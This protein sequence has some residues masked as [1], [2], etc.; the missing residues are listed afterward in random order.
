MKRSLLPEKEL[1]QKARDLR[2]TLLTMLH[3]AGSGHPG[4]SLSI[5]D[6]LVVLFYRGLLETNPEDP[7]WKDRDRLILS[8]GHAC[9]ALYVVLADNGFFPKEELAYLRKFGHLLHQGSADVK[10]PGIEFPG[11]SL[12]QGLSGGIGMAL[13]ARYLGSPSHIFVIMG[14]GESQEGQIWEALMAGGH[15]KLK[16][17]TAILDYNKL[18]GDGPVEK[19]MRLEPLVDKIR[20]FGWKVKEIDGHD[21]RQIEEAFRDAKKREED[22]PVYLIAH[23]VKGKGVSFMENQGKWHGSNVPNR[24]ELEL[25]LEE[26]AK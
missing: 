13:A 7:K 15:Y 6:I 22:A 11:G 20:S 4:G 1:A 9:P 26:L 18:Q 17:L 14:D 25:A 10:V 5:L 8:K 3:Q 19:T 2:R 24:E 23:T 21:Y 16:N 12:G